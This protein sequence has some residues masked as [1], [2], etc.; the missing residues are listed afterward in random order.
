MTDGWVR[1]SILKSTETQET[2]Q[3]EQQ[4]VVENSTVETNQEQEK[5]PEVTD[6]KE[7]TTTVKSISKTGYV[8]ADGLIVRSIYIK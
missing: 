6:K 7:E 8:S 1:K 4:P 3:E 5:E 2:Q